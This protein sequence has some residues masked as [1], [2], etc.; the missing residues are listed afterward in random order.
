MLIKFLVEFKRKNGLRAAREIAIFIE[1]R[2]GY[3]NKNTAALR[4]YSPYHTSC[5]LLEDNNGER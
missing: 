1:N 2:V 3:V 5:I 4:S